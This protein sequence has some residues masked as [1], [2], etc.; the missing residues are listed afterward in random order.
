MNRNKTLLTNTVMLLVVLAH[1]QAH[2]EGTLKIFL[3]AGQSNTVGHARTFYEGTP[4]PGNSPYQMEYLA[5]NPAFV[6][7]L[8]PN[9][10]TFK[11]HFEANWMQPRNDAWGLH[12]ASSSGST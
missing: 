3:M 10:Y 9:I 11:D 6:T 7:G 1:T 2:A 5:D 12:I 4:N 8:D